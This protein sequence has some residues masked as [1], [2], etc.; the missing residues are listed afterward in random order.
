MDSSPIS[1][2][3]SVKFGALERTQ[4]GKLEEVGVEEIEEEIKFFDE[5]GDAS[6]NVVGDES[7]ELITL[8]GGEKRVLGEEERWVPVELIDSSTLNSKSEERDFVV[9]DCD[10]SSK[11]VGDECLEFI[12]L[13]REEGRFLVKKKDGFLLN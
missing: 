9:E 1:S 7:L 6:L 12:A 5:D 4:K 3:D 8:M 10:K 2:L 13:M 11:M